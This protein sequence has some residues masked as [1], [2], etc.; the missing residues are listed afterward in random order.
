MDGLPAPVALV[1]GLSWAQNLVLTTD[2]SKSSQKV[3]SQAEQSAVDS[4]PLQFSG[5]DH[6]QQ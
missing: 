2:P 1:N 4:R 5:N 3:S 6:L